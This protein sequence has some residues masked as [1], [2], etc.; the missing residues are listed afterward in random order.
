MNEPRSMIERARTALYGALAAAALVVGASK[1][2]NAGGVQSQMNEMF[3]SMTNTTSPQLSMG[4]RRGVLSGGSFVMRNNIVDVGP[5][6]TVDFPSVSAGCGGV[7]VFGGNFAMLNTDRL[8]ELPRAIM[9]NAGSMAVD[10]A[11]GAVSPQLQSLMAKWREWIA[12]WGLD[13][14]NS[15]KMAKNLLDKTGAAAAIANTTARLTSIEGWGDDNGTGSTQAG[16]DQ[17]SATT[18]A[19][20]DPEQS[21]RLQPGNAIWRAM[22]GSEAHRFFPSGDDTL[23]QDIMALTGTFIA[24]QKG[25]DNCSPPAS[26]QAD[27]FADG[28]VMAWDEPYALSLQD[29]VR[30]TIDGRQPKTMR[31]EGGTAM[32]QCLKVSRPTFDYRGLA[33]EVL[34]I[35]IG[36]DESTG[37]INRFRAGQEGPTP[38]ETAFLVNTGKFGAIILRIARED[39]EAAQ[40]FVQAYAEPIAAQLAYNLVDSLLY[41]AEAASGGSV[42]N[43]SRDRIRELLSDA[44]HRLQFQMREFNEM[45][46]AQMS[47]LQYYNQLAMNFEV[48]SFELPSRGNQ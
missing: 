24:C 25:N 15:C 48:R 34:D 45:Q 28:E 3:G 33:R 18:V 14:L 20:N 10:I 21:E 12:K 22:K 43:I 47:M 2:A 19:E 29:L 37:I 17:T 8:R 6:Y 4:A 36:T 46:S 1:P 5:L 35:M 39:P 41:G 38:R 9:A 30:G 32:E 23:L 16:D 31:C 44:R 27:N 11:L 26:A 7:D 40:E 13:D 42:N